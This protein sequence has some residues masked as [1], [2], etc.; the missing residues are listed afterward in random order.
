MKPTSNPH[1][2]E[3]AEDAQLK[4]NDQFEGKGEGGRGISRTK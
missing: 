4:N 2:G 3:G 1:R